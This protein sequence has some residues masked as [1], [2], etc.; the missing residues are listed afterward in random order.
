M[1]PMKKPK[2]SVAASSTKKPK[3]TFSRFTRTS[4]RR[5][6]LILARRRHFRA[7]NHTGGWMQRA[8]PSG[9]GDSTTAPPGRL[10]PLPVTATDLDRDVVRLGPL[11]VR[12][13]R[14][15]TW[16]RA[17][18][19]LFTVAAGTNVPTPL[20][21][22]YQER[23]DLSAEVLTA[24]FG[25]YA[26]GLV[27]ALLLAG[28]LSDRLGRRKVAI[29]GIVLS[30]IASLAFAAAGDSLTLLFLARFAQGVVSGV[31]FSVGSAWVGELSVASGEGAG[32]RRA[33]VAMTAGFSLGPLTSGLLGQYAPAPTVLPYL[34]HT[35]LVGVGLALAVRLPE[36]V[37]LRSG[38]RRDDG[39][40]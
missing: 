19:A 39:D 3:T 18:F 37:V 26:A 11:R 24:L 12:R 28:P 10:G 14:P 8:P 4:R 36:T 32:G 27:P 40:P 29:P 30:A 15:V 35:V 17:V 25:C 7:P 16:K 1:S 38:R 33:A 20:L 9:R 21:L 23:L 5:L 31:V 22:V 6:P 13:V 2:F 34:L